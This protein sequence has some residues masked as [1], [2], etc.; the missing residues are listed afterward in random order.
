MKSRLNKV[1]RF[2]SLG[3]IVH[4]ASV[5]YVECLIKRVYI[6]GIYWKYFH[7][8]RH[9][10]EKEKADWKQRKRLKKICN[11]MR[12]WMQAPSANRSQPRHRARH[13][14]ASGAA[15]GS[16]LFQSEACGFARI[17]VFLR[18]SLLLLL[19]PLSTFRDRSNYAEYIRR[20]V[21]SYGEKF[22]RCHVCLSSVLIFAQVPSIT[23]KLAY[24]WKSIPIYVCN[25]YGL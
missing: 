8:A 7:L 25:K 17:A 21:Y 14:P 16:G 12:A 20:F 18:L 11:L 23:C 13:A 4:R 5:N 6:K 2:T 22:G 19:S 15:F 10:R 9:I 1:Q 24:F 3:M